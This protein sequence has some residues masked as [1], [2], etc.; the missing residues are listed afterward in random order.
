MAHIHVIGGGLIGMLTARELALAGAK[1]TL[2]EKG[3]LGQ[4]SSWAGGGILSPL[5]PWRYPE[6]VTAL[7]QWSQAHY[8]AL[9]EALA[10]Q[11]GIDPEW[12][13]SGLL[14]L[15]ADEKDEALRWASGHRYGLQLIEGAAVGACE[16]AVGTPSGEALW[17]PEVAQVR[18]P[19]L[20]Q[21]MRAEIRRLDV[22]VREGVEVRGFR[23]QAGT[24]QGIVTSG[25][26]MTAGS[27]LLAGGAWTGALLQ[28]TGINLP[29]K[30]VRGQMLLFQGQP[31]LVR[32]MVMKGDRYVIP[33]RDG[34]ILVGSTLEDVGF[35]KETTAE[36][37]ADLRAAAIGIIPALA[38]LPIE[39]HWAGLRP[40]SPTGVPYVGEHP[41]VRG[42]YVNAGHFRNGVVLGLASC[43]LAADLILARE[44]ILDPAP[45]TLNECVDA[46]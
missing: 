3:A 36:A 20:L 4:E 16:P 39:R 45:Y 35:K 23:T 8:P 25:G 5:H 37:F 7:A 2:L 43:R 34:R 14:W 32:R 22:T 6:A 12:T 28:E 38:D 33:R 44:P 13:Q 29:V 31:G 15:D 42:L 11:T 27:V 26:E 41:G 17:L 21:A 30:P 1:V 19:R 10:A 18:N 24:I 9:T 40:G 46:Q